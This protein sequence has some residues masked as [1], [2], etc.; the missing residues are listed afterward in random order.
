MGSQVVT[1]YEDK[2]KTNALY[3]RTKTSAIS[4]DDGKAL[5]QIISELNSNFNG[6][7]LCPTLLSDYSNG[8]S[9]NYN[10]DGTYRLN[11][12]ASSLIK[13]I[14]GT[15][16]L[17]PGKQYK[18]LGCPSGGGNPG[19]RISDD[20]ASNSDIGDGVVFTA[21]DRKNEIKIVI[22]N[23]VKVSDLIFK[24][25][26]TEN[27]GLTYNDFKSFDDSYVK[28][29]ESGAKIDLVKRF[30]LAKDH[31]LATDE[32]LSFYADKPYKFFIIEFMTSTS[33]LDSKNETHVTKIITPEMLLTNI[34]VEGI[35]NTTRYSRVFSMARYLINGRYRWDI[36]T[37][38]CSSTKGC[39]PAN[40]YGVY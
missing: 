9:C 26:V 18:I 15:V 38:K 31:T 3:P 35:S 29:R 2:A 8:V 33:T 6:N 24:P 11:G 12:T 28:G 32:I 21:T 5:S 14:V 30:A 17:E 10:N 27:L 16:Y 25:M 39:I 13:F 20:Q 7:L 34:F 4:D 22:S 37:I 40:I 36:N 23:G 19:Y 1:L